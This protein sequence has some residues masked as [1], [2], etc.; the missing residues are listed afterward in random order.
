MAPPLSV[1]ASKPPS[2][3]APHVVAS[4]PAACP[5]S[6]SGV[7]DAACRGHRLRV[8]AAPPAQAQHPSGEKDARAVV[9]VPRWNASPMS[10][11][12]LLSVRKSMMQRELSELQD[13]TSFG[14]PGH[15]STLMMPDAEPVLLT[16]FSRGR[17]LTRGSEQLMA[18]SPHRGSH[19][20]SEPS[21]WPVTTIAAPTSGTAAIHI[22]TLSGSHVR[23]EVQR[24]ASRSHIW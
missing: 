21:A 8:P 14:L 4:T 16:W 11:R 7:S 18:A 1:L 17:H 15:T 9:P 3:Y 23:L 20:E 12:L 6:T 13:S 22:G 5:R 2:G 19:T 24:P 10:R